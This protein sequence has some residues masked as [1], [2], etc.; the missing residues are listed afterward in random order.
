MTGQIEPGAVNTLIVFVE[1]DLRLIAAAVPDQTR[2]SM[3]YASLPA[4]D[5]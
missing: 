1:N 3:A 5:L 4:D 2:V